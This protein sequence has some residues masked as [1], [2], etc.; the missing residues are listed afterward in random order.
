MDSYCLGVTVVFSWPATVIT[1]TVVAFPL[2]YK[3]QGALNKSIVFFWLPELLG[4]RKQQYSGG[5]F[6]R[7]LGRELLLEPF[8]LLR[9]LGE[10]ATLMLAGNI[11]GQTQTIPVAIYFAVE[12]GDMKQ[13]SVWV[14]VILAISLTVLT[15]VNFWSDSRRSVAVKARGE[16]SREAGDLY[17]CQH[18][19]LSLSLPT[20]LTPKRPK[21]TDCRHSKATPWFCLETSF[22]T[23]LDTL[24]L[25]RFWCG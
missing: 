14:L 2:M 19:S 13:A 20:F 8:S 6:Y 4:R 17:G 21:R 18:Y 11:P 15:A 16:E 7:C 9:A 1:A 24:G 5:S 3:T 12:A 25:R 10:F 23:A 22:T